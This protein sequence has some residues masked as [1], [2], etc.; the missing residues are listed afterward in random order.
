MTDIQ[1][2]AADISAA[3]EMIV[4]TRTNREVNEAITIDLCAAATAAHALQVV[5]MTATIKLQITANGNKVMKEIR[6]AGLSLEEAGKI[7]SGL[8]RTPEDLMRFPIEAKT[9]AEFWKNEGFEM[10]PPRH[11]WPI[12]KDPVGPT[13][14]NG[15]SANTEWPIDVLNS[16][17]Y[18]RGADIFTKS[19]SYCIEWLEEDR[20]TRGE[21]MT[22]FISTV[23]WSPSTLARRTANARESAM[24][25]LK[26]LTREFLVHVNPDLEPDR[27]A[28]EG[29][30]LEWTFGIDPAPTLESY[31]NGSLR[32][33]S[34]EYILLQSLAL[35]NTGARV[36]L[37]ITGCA[38]F[39]G[40]QEHW[41]A[42]ADEWSHLHIELAVCVQYAEGLSDQW[43]RIRARGE[44]IRAWHVF[45]LRRLLEVWEGTT[46]D[47]VY[48]E[49]I[50]EMDSEF[51]WRDTRRNATKA[52][53]E[54]EEI[55]P[56]DG[57]TRNRN[58]K[59]E[60]FE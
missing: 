2:I 34:S 5:I 6:L 51:A 38:G 10:V 45:D 36:V 35:M 31:V 30:L 49:W 8:D 12:P 22:L 43:L 57:R 14:T 33:G 21:R 16:E 29:L 20:E 13:A 1:R 42:F 44:M 9:L 40:V 55:A 11:M 32:V 19:R 28:E 25:T 39:L 56:T 54:L 7:N 17:T 4:V 18:R 27:Y 24:K 15:P 50:L 47:P 3:R 58:P 46:Q 60:D 23:R 41:A 53:Y 48:E 37:Q 26:G 59:V 52:V